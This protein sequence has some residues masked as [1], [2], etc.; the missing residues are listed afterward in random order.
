[1][2]GGARGLLWE[3]LHEWTILKDRDKRTAPYWKSLLCVILSSSRH[4][5]LL[6][7]RRRPLSLKTQSVPRI[8]SR[9]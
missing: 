3:L 4:I 6:K 8:S 1:M 5:K 9:L 2:T 7:T